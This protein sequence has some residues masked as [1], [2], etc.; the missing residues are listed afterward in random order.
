M[1]YADSAETAHRWATERSI[2]L[3]AFFAGDLADVDVTALT[4][5]FATARADG[6]R[7][8]LVVPD[9]RTASAAERG[10]A[11]FVVDGQS[12]PSPFGLFTAL[13]V[14]GV[15]DARRLGVLGASV[16]TIQ[17]GHRAGAGIVVGIAVE[18]STVRRPLLEAQPDIITAADGFAA[19]DATRCASNRAHRQR[20]LLN[21]GPS[22]V[23]DRVHRAVG[24]PDL[25]HREPEYPEILDGVRRKLLKLA[26]VSDEWAMVMLAGSGTAAM[27]AMTGASTRPGRKLLVCKNGIYGERIETI[28]RRLGTEVVTVGASDLQPIDPAAVAA[29]LDAD[30]LIDAVA[31][32]HHETTAGLLNPIHEIAAESNRRGVLVLVDAISSFGS[33]HLDLDGTGIDFVASTSNKCL[34]GLPGAAFVLVSPRGQERI[35]AVP[36]RSLYFDLPGYLKAQAKR[37]VPFTPAIPAIYGLDAALDELLDEGLEHRQGYYQARMD[38]LDREFTRLGLEPRVAPGLRSRCVRSL[39]LPEGISYDTLHDAVKADGYIIYGGLGEAA[40]TSFRVCALGALKIEALQG[41]I[42]S[43]ERAVSTNSIAVGA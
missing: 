6:A 19:L 4:A 17:S 24:G 30:P 16:D 25:C 31:V 15:A 35:N 8:A 1:P 12:A 32:I 3:W 42:A 28:A 5:G 41:F 23:S 39:P 36:P 40:K 18:D 34:H 13:Q 10:V 26:G 27:E 9:G 2:A 7:F 21:P 29:A 14:A 20:V 22:V 33:E 37:T 11:D 43:L 38:Y